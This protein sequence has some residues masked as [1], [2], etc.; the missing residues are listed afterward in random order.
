[1]SADH[2]LDTNILIYLFDETD[3]EKSRTATSLVERSLAEG[4]GCISWQVVQES[5]NVLTRKLAATPEDAKRFLDTVLQPLWLVYPSGSLYRNAL[6][7]RSR[8]RFGLYDSLIVASAIEAGCRILFSEDLQD[9]QTIGN[10]TI[11]NPLSG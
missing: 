6:D 8:Y 11:R 1:M 9:G 10:L 7:V 2:F 3:E 5:I 4:S